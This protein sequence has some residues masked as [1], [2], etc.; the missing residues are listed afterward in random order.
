MLHKENKVLGVSE[1][2]S[3]AIQKIKNATDSPFLT[4]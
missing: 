2:Q 1:Q 4:I 3:L